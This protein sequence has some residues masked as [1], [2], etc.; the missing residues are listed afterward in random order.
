MIG[1]ISTARIIGSN[2]PMGYSILYRNHS[3]YKMTLAKE[4]AQSQ[5]MA[6]HDV[7]QLGSLVWWWRW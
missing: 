1:L 4:V 2:Q 5:R 6:H 3:Q 7:S